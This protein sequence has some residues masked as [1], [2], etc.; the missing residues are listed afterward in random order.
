MILACSNRPVPSLSRQQVV[1]ARSGRSHALTRASVPV[2]QAGGQLAVL[3]GHRRPRQAGR[4][5]A[6]LA[7]H[8][9]GE[10]G[11]GEHAGAARPRSPSGPVGPRS[12]RPRRTGARPRAGSRWRPPAGRRS[13]PRS[14]P[15]RSP[16]PAS[17]RAAA[18]R[19]RP[20]RSGCSS[21]ACEVA[22][23]E[24]DQV[25]DAEAA[26][27]GPPA[28]S[29]SLARRARRTWG[30]VC[31]TT[32][33]RGAGSQ[34]AQRGHRLDAPLDPLAPPEQTPG[35]NHRAAGSPRPRRS[36]AR[37]WPA[38]APCGIDP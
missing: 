32:T 24:L 19:R 28:S 9:A 38:C 23:V 4:Q 34:V 8:P 14:A 3:L 10:T 20:A 26:R 36:G 13:P 11:L 30:W 33:Y 5:A 37:P 35:Q 25:R 27:P 16:G 7:G 6:A 22:G 17:R 21:P 15:R 31:P 18:R 29:G 12:G 2:E 1:E